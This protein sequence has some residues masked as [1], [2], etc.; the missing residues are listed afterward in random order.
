MI[1]EIV[2]KRRTEVEQYCADNNLS[3]EKLFSS[4]CS[5]DKKSVFI[6]GK[7]GDPDREKLGLKDNIPSPVLLKIFLENGKLRFEQ[8]EHTQK[9]LGATLHAVAV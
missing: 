3:S 4:S 1:R 6:T 8:T 2:N 5:C 7:W 9:Y